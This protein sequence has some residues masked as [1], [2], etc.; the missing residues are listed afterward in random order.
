MKLDIG[1]GLNKK[2][3]HL[4][5]DKLA[6]PS[7][8]FQ[9]DL[10][11]FPYPFKS[12]F[13]EEVWMDQT[14]EHLNDPLKVMEELHRICQN[15]A[16]LTV[17]VPYFRSFYAVIDPTHRNFFSTY[18]FAYFD[19]AHPFNQRYRYSAAKFKVKKIEFDREFVKKGLIHKI[20]ARIAN[21]YPNFYEAKISHLYPLN[22][23][24]FYLETIK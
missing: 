10:N 23:L 1:C 21:K 17:G 18:W 8:D 22:S 4:G 14:L 20:I 3:G 19:P 9:H 13:I 2:P 15:G 24:T 6:L 7:V 11:I 5:I 12:D 16:P